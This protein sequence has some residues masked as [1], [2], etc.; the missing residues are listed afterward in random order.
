M[1]KDQLLNEIG[2]WVS[3]A[4]VILM[5]Y[6]LLTYILGTQLSYGA[7][8]KH[9]YKWSS[10]QTVKFHFALTYEKV[11]SGYQERMLYKMPGKTVTPCTSHTATG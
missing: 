9:L 10:V 8:L 5:N 1:V 2:Y 7:E 3:Y 6:S 11:R 4:G